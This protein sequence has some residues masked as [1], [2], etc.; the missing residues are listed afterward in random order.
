[1]SISSLISFLGEH[2]VSLC[3]KQGH[4]HYHSPVTITEDYL[5]LLKK[6]KD[7]LI[8]SLVLYNEQDVLIGPLSHN[9]QSLWFS[10]LLAP[11]SSS[12][13]VAVPMKILSRLNPVRIQK[14][15]AA[16]SECHDQLRATFH[17]ISDESES[18]PFQLI[19][20]KQYYCFSSIDV[21]GFS[22][23]R[24]NEQILNFYRKPF[25]LSVSPAWRTALFSRS[26]SEHILIFLFHHI[27]CDAHSIGVFLKNFD[28][29][30]CGQSLSLSAISGYT[31]FVTHQIRYLRKNQNSLLGYW[32]SRAGINIGNSLPTDFDRKAVRS[33]RGKTVFFSIKKE[34]RQ[35]VPLLAARLSITQF[36][37]YF[38]CF[39]LL[40]MLR[41]G[42]FDITT[43]VLTSGRCDQRFS[44]TIGYFVNPL[45]VFCNRQ[46]KQ[47]IKD[48]FHI[49]H[50]D[51]C[52]LLDNQNYP[53]SLLVN[54]IH[55]ERRAD[56]PVLFSTIF[57]MLSRKQLHLASDL[58][59][60]NEDTADLS[61]CGMPIKPYPLN[62]Q[63]G[64]FDLTLELIEKENDVRGVLKYD[65]ELFTFESVSWFS[66]TYNAILAEVTA[67]PDISISELFQ[68]LNRKN[69]PESEKTGWHLTIA[70]TFTANMLEESF[71]FWESVTGLSISAEFSPFYHIEQFLQQNMSFQTGRKKY[72]FFLIRLEDLAY[73]RELD[74]SIDLQYIRSRASELVDHLLQS[75]ANYRLQFIIIFCPLSSEVQN[76]LELK[77]G[78]EE[79]EKLMISRLDCEKHLYCIASEK[80]ISSF[81]STVDYQSPVGLVGQVPYTEYFYEQ[82][83]KIIVRTVYSFEKPPCK[84]I[85]LDCDNTLWTGV[86]GEDPL[87]SIKIPEPLRNFQ[88]FFVLC[89]ERGIPVCLCSKNNREDTITV[90][91]QHPDMILKLSDISF[92][93]I[94][95]QPKSQNIA[96]ICAEANLTATG[97]IFIDDNP[98]ECAEVSANCPDIIVIHLP[99]AISDRIRYV[100]N[101]WAFDTPKVTAEDLSRIEKFRVEKFRSEFRKQVSSFSEF[102]KGLNLQISIRNALPDDIPR[103]SQLSLRTNQFTS[104]ISALTEEE[105]HESLKLHNLFVMEVSDRFG[106]YGLVGV[107]KGH[108][109]KE[110]YVVDSFFLSCRALGRGVEHRCISFIGDYAS[111]NGC[112]YVRVS[113]NPTSRNKP[114]QL[115]LQDTIFKYQF[116]SGPQQIIYEVPSRVLEQI[117]FN[118]EVTTSHQVIGSEQDNAINSVSSRFCLSTHI[119]DKIARCFSTAEA[120]HQQILS[121]RKSKCKSTETGT[122]NKLCNADKSAETPIERVI[123][124][125]WSE[126]L[127]REAISVHQNFFDAG[128][129]SLMLPHIVQKISKCLNRT[130]SLVE[131]FQYPTISSLAT[132][133]S[134]KEIE[135]GSSSKN[136][137]TALQNSAYSRFRSKKAS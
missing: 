134:S 38:G 81:D 96:E 98:A 133:L 26:S 75:A 90:F 28:E 77:S 59:Y 109:A 39:Q 42:S 33:N 110:M 107:I 120:L 36:S 13:N 25:T 132:H 95:W 61:F 37:I 128:G 80:L 27:I 31:D 20:L 14:T 115:F 9:Q 121:M 6:S 130:V 72:A 76:N 3:L 4:I 68:K 131:L 7:Q 104:G 111:K 17:V 11:D 50:R 94:N 1:M 57:N 97:I 60:S 29:Y 103:I 45:P 125:I 105:A 78:F 112:S 117:A 53:L 87:T 136:D 21:S 22:D 73:H 108:K 70:S 47:L 10:Y 92:D 55:V 91:E 118:P 43:G 106:D 15:L 46:E 48:H 74:Q 44:N 49:T 135:P 122:E 82:L 65:S 89:K 30:Y 8:E 93:R 71:Q 102:I 85:I 12:Y 79:I 24:L 67:S 58:V 86:A 62:Q 123:T 40:Y 23:T 66:S 114:F 69:N 116:S 84:G 100:E 34:I 124:R 99:E 63:E 18:V 52:E 119:L 127:G 41:S 129:N 32:K 126:S 113:V 2:Q 137:R 51:I 56:R 88:R 16:L 101:F 54:N 83:G 5:E 64:Q 35:Q 19:P